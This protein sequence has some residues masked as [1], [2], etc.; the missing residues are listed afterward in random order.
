MK[1]IK[2]FSISFV[3]AAIM[4][5][6]FITQVAMANDQYSAENIYLDQIKTYT[7]T[8]DWDNGIY[9]NEHYYSFTPNSSGYYDFTV[10]GNNASNEIYMV[11]YDNCGNE[12]DFEG[13]PSNVFNYI[14]I[15]KLQANTNYIIKVS[16]FDSGIFSLSITTH[17]HNDNDPYINKA[18]CS[19]YGNMNGKIYYYCDYCY[20]NWTKNIKRVSSVKLSNKIYKYNGKTKKPSVTVKLSDGTKLNKKYYSVIYPKKSVKPGKYT[21]KIKF[22]GLY[23]GNITKTYTIK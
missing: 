11:L 16:T 13:M 17:N 4:S 20:Y 19:N 10:S 18:Y 15:F 22:K 9:D 1:K 5:L 2:V 14:K 6:L 7:Y 21:V 8:E 3:I 23:E 12:V